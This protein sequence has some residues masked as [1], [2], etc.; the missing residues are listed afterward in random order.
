MKVLQLKEIYNVIQHHQIY[1]IDYVI[2]II[3][4]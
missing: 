3:I 4:L 1:L 2:N